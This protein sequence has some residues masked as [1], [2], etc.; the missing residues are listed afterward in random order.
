MNSPFQLVSKLLSRKQ[1]PQSTKYL[2]RNFSNIPN[3]NDNSGKYLVIFIGITLLLG[4]SY[5]IGAPLYKMY[6]KR[7]KFREETP[8]DIVRISLKKDSEEK[9]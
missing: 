3:K 7:R 1:F 4:I 8:S 9:N 5:P 2:K 6:E